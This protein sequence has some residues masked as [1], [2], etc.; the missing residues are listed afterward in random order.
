MVGRFD[1]RVDA[2]AAFSYQWR[3][4][5]PGFERGPSV[6]IQP[7]GHVVHNGEP[8]CTIPVGEWIRFEVECQLGETT[9]GTFEMRVR[10]PGDD[11]PRVFEG[12]P[13]EPGFKELDWVGFVANGQ[14]ETVFYVDN[15]EVRPAE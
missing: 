7:G 4:Y 13:C 9:A 11:A 15:V 8:L 14:R 5:T 2:A 12:L 6:T 10:V 1:L 3:D